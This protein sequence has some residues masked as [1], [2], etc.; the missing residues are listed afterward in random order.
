MVKESEEKI[1]KVRRTYSY[2]CDDCNVHIGDVVEYD[3]GYVPEPSGR[4]NLRWRVNNTEY[5]LDRFL[6]PECSNKLYIKLDR[7]LK[8]FGFE[9]DKDRR[10][11]NE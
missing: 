9:S 6:C 2:Y 11:S 4:V 5:S 3:D 1:I 10:K 8:D 7:L